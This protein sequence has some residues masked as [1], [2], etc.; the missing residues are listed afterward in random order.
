MKYVTFCII[1]LLSQLA[2]APAYN[3]NQYHYITDDYVAH[4]IPPT[5]SIEQTTNW[6]NVVESQELICLAKNIYFEARSESELGW[7]AVAMVTINR[8]NDNKFPNTICG[9]VWQSNRSKRTGRVVAQF[10]WTLDGKSDM[11]D[12]RMWTK[13]ITKA[14]TILNKH[15]SPHI[16]LR[17]VTGGALFYHADY[18]NPKWSRSPKLQH[19]V[20]I[21]SHQFFKKM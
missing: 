18:V 11:P 13:I 5:L 19:T 3:Y 14:A 21:G 17:D 15:N 4:V 9:V 20:S 16:D 6:G 1:M 12:G 2:N 10:S 8:V 7:T